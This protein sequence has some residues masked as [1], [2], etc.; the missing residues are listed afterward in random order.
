MSDRRNNCELGANCICNRDGVPHCAH[1]NQ[2]TSRTP[3][4]LA[5]LILA[6]SVLFVGIGMSVV[7][8]QYWVRP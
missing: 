1:L 7:A 3:F 8:F 4:I 2:D 5:I 6:T